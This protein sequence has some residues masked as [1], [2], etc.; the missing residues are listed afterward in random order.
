MKALKL[1]LPLIPIVLALFLS[2]A[3]SLQ[4]S[5][6]N[7]HTHAENQDNDKYNGGA[8][9]TTVNEQPSLD[10]ATDSNKA[11]SYNYYGTFNVFPKAGSFWT[12]HH[13][14]IEGLSA[15]FVALF[16][17]A[18]VVT[19]IY[20]W[21]V[22]KQSA[23]AATENAKT[24]V[25]QMQRGQRAFVFLK[26]FDAIRILDPTRQTIVSYRFTAIWEN[27]G[28]TPTNNMTSHSNVIWPATPIPNGYDFVAIGD[29]TPIQLVLRPHAE[30]GGF[31]LYVPLQVLL[32]VLHGERQLYFYG[33]A[34]YRGVFDGT[35]EHRTRFCWQIPAIFGDPANVN[36]Q[37]TFT[38]S[39]HLEHNDAT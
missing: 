1:S 9:I 36:G 10:S 20:Q 32:D 29:T 17:G 15:I 28:V 22:A 6:P 21:K 26:R 38:F 25:I 14:L 3:K 39:V 23:D 27:T 18:L 19:S 8:P 31:P 7:R 5:N 12:R 37:C 34:L 16:T 30:F 24:A 11:E 4:A 13:D 35:P 33:W 2:G